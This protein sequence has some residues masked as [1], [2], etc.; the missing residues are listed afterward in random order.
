M[1]L[2]CNLVPG[3]GVYPQRPK[4]LGQAWLQAAYGDDDKPEAKG[5]P[6]LAAL[7]AG[8][9]PV[10][11]ASSLLSWNQNKPAKKSGKDSETNFLKYM[12]TSL[13]QKALQAD[14]N[15][16]NAAGIDLKMLKPN[17]RKLLDVHGQAS[18]QQQSKAASSGQG[19]ELVDQPSA[20]Q[21][22]LQ[23]PAMNEAEQVQG[24][25]GS[26]KVEGKDSGTACC[27]QNSCRF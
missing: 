15:G 16:Q 25:P 3:K 4:D 14:N 12:M 21:L 2:P 5:L 19:E 10:R 7:V 8:H 23:L 27:W 1:N 20:T 26:K 18:I 9:I 24:S 13:T 11:S 6:G 22:A 17:S